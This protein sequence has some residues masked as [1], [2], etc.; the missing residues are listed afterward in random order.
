MR[1]KC[2]GD[3][4]VKM[5]DEFSSEDGHGKEMRRVAICGPKAIQIGRRAIPR[6]K[7]STG[8]DAY[9]RMHSRDKRVFQH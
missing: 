3:I 7:G 1:M 5:V 2:M 8:L 9:T 6:H 4:V